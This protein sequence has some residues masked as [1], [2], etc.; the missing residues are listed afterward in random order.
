[1]DERR[2][3]FL[4]GVGTTAA[5]VGTAGCMGR[6][7]T[8]GGGPEEPPAETA[9]TQFRGETT[10]RGIDPERT[11]PSSVTVDWRLDGLNTGGHTAAKG[12]P[13]LAP[14]GDIVVTGDTGEVWAVRPDGRRRWRADATDTSRG[15][16]GTPAV[17]NGTV[18][19]GAYD[20]AL[21]AFD[22]ETGEQYWRTQL[23]DAIG[24]SP[25]YHDGRLY[26]AV[27]YYE[28]SGAIFALDAVTGEVR[29]EDRRIT[30]HPHSTC[31]IDRAAGRLVVGSN[32][33]SLYG[34]SYPD[35]EF[36]WRYDTGEE[37]KGPIATWDGS[38]FFGSWSDRVYRVA[39]SDGTEQ[40]AT[41][42][43]ASVMAGPAVEGA[44]GTVYVGDQHDS[45]YALD[46]DSGDEGWE[47]DVGGPV[48][49]CPTVTSEHV[50]VGSYEPTLSALAK[51]TGEE[52]W[53]V[54]AEGEVTSTPLVTDSAIYVAE[55]TSEASLEGEGP[56]GGLYRIVAD[57]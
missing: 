32:D 29:W 13:V 45:L 14:N 11:I 23:G 54:P 22:L 48:I 2:R 56:T 21:Y 16:H 39:L 3:R 55:R 49:G 26:I 4:A 53:T 7:R 12:S 5:A 27:E 41:D 40:W 42:L 34:W 17:A 46:A 18:Y 24:S 47:T 31:A 50:L 52:V 10:R 15:F 19:V 35:H 20:G 51:S 1:M 28:P 9:D 57:E 6:L 8:L 38:A 43:G 33:G 25:G 36:L 44:T 30:D 37:I